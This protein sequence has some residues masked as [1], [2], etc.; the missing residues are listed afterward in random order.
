M[1]VK[2]K[3]MGSLYAFTPRDDSNITLPDDGKIELEEGTTIRQLLDMLEVSKLAQAVTLNE[4]IVKDR[5][6]VL[7]NKD[8]LCII[9]IVGGG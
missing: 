7:N 8:R 6:D 4:E 9:G 1:I 2:V 5:D 3:M